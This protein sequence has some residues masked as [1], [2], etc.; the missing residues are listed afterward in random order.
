MADLD[1]RTQDGLAVSIVNAS[2]A[3]DQ[4]AQ[5]SSVQLD[6]AQLGL[7][8]QYVN[9]SNAD[10]SFTSDVLQAKL[11]ANAVLS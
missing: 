3:L 6:F 1:F 10:L 11:D 5:R 7:S 9:H 4:D 8:A 2:A